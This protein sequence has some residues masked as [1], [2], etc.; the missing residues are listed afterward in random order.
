MNYAELSSNFPHPL[1]KLTSEKLVQ[2]TNEAWNRFS[3]E[4]GLDTSCFLHSLTVSENLKTSFDERKHAVDVVQIV[5]H[6][7]QVTIS[8]VKDGYMVLLIDITDIKARQKRALELASLDTLT[9]LCNRRS[10]LDSVLTQVQSR[11]FSEEHSLLFI[12][13]NRFKWVNDTYG[14]KVGDKLLNLVAVRLKHVL[15]EDTLLCRWGGDEFVAFLPSASALQTKAIT[16]RCHRS[17]KQAFKLGEVQLHISASIGSSS[18][19]GSTQDIEAVVE[20]ADKAMYAE[21]ARCYNG[22]VRSDATHLAA[23]GF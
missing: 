23:G 19:K 2:E 12:D 22:T 1:I 17:L 6:Y 20:Q 4:N 13:L 16:K 10:F 18:F 9:G 15:R 5:N 14:H 8:P 3:S 7:F 11:K 21:K